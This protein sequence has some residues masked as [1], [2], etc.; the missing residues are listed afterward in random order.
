MSLKD[1]AKKEVE[2]ACERERA[3]SE[4]QESGMW[5]YGCACYESALKAFNSLLED[6]H[7]GMSIGFTKN[8]LMRLIDGQPLTPIEDT[9]DVWE[10]RTDWM[11]EEE[12]GYRHYQCKRCSALFK[13]VYSD[14]TIKYSYNDQYYCVDKYSGSTYRNSFIGRIIHEM[15]PITMPFMPDKPIKVYCSDL[16]TDRKNGDFDSMAVYYAVKPDGE[17]I[18]IY[19]YFKEGN[20][21]SGWVE[22]DETEWSERELEH[23]A[24]MQ[25]E[26]LETEKETSK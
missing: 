22:I 26:K 14:G 19:R 9:E 18:D 23:I 13:T 21:E 20:T 6:G 3:G 4:S 12:V 11:S 5:D 10:D 7:S 8:I 17:K 24:R 1:W 15:F 25:R 16:L 2:I